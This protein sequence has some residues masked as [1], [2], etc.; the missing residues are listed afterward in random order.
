MNATEYHARLTGRTLEGH[1][2][3]AAEEALADLLKCDLK[4]VRA[5][6]T[7]KGTFKK[8]S[9]RAKACKYIAAV[10]N[11]GLECQLFEL[12]PTNTQADAQSDEPAEDRKVAINRKVGMVV[13]MIGCFS[14]FGWL[15]VSDGYYP[16]NGFLWSISNTM[17]VYSGRPFGCGTSETLSIDR[18][19]IV[20]KEDC[21]KGWTLSIYT[22][23]LI[24]GSL[25]LIAY[26]FVLFLNL[27]CTPRRLLMRLG[28]SLPERGERIT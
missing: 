18:T 28:A 13:M 22:S 19:Y 26:G 17:T 14:I 21:T 8:S 2:T 1:E 25:A 24:L 12:T 20:T 23:H 5:L 3:R 15:L 9:D 10:E 11:V 6:L 27:I 4:K 7:K 16:E